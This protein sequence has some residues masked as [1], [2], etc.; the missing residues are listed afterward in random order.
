[1]HPFLPQKRLFRAYDIRGDY[2]YFTDD[3]VC[4]MAANFA[5]HFTNATSDCNNKPK[6]KTQ[7]VLGYD[8]R[9]GSL[10][11]AKKMAVIF[12]QLNIEVIWLGLVTTPMMAFL[13]EEYQG[14]GIIVTASHSAKHYTGFKWVTS[15]QSPNTSEIYSLYNQLAELPITIPTPIELAKQWA[16]CKAHIIDISDKT[17]ELYEYAINNAIN[18]I[19][20]QN[21]HN[22]NTQTTPTDILIDT[23][24]VDC[25]NGATSNFVKSIFGQYVNNLIV[26]NDTTD[27][28]FPHGDPDPSIP[29]RLEQL[30]NS[31][32]SNKAQLGIA[33]DGDG[34]RL[35]V[36]DNKGQAIAADNLLYLL[37]KTAITNQKTENKTMTPEVLFDVKCSHHLHSML[38]ELGTTP[39]MSRTGSSH[40]RKDLQTGHSTAIFAGELS[41]HFIFNDGYFINHDDGMY[42]ALR[43][44]QWLSNQPQAL[45]F[46][47]SQLPT[48]VSTADIYIPIVEQQK[49]LLLN[50]VQIIQSWL[51]SLGNELNGV[52]KNN[53]TNKKPPI[54]LPKNAQVSTI[55]GIRLDFP[56][57][58]GVIRPSNTSHCMTVRFAGNTKSDIKKIQQKLVAL[59]RQF[60]D[61]LAKQVASIKPLAV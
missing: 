26:L 49:T 9:L 57:G 44:I 48:M 28:N 23:L 52:T 4:A 5:N 7:V 39:V 16:A 37:A 21:T 59:C 51:Q 8:T 2:R 20:Q 41:G 19:K 3:F 24:V 34:D 27:G 31:V 29:G 11:I 12:Y 38:T 45:H 33:F 42:A 6:Q 43:L 50:L 10:P 35:T 17:C 61:Q 54:K 47:V 56:N 60:D 55:D 25:L 32:I 1:M 36:V 30:Q 18:S 15:G 58:F 22:V 40:M 53:N 13:A 14:H 46:I